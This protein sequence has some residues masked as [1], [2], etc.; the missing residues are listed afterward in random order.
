MP[1]NYMAYDIDVKIYAIHQTPILV[2]IDATPN[3]YPTYTSRL[4]RAL[5][6]HRCSAPHWKPLRVLLTYRL[7]LP[8]RRG[9]YFPS[10]YVHFYTDSL[11]GGPE[12]IRSSVPGLKELVGM[13]GVFA[14]CWLRDGLL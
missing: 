6:S 9:R 11:V 4:H 14:R 8:R 7:Q 12:A 2:V 1:V 13:L 5:Y 3:N 10:P